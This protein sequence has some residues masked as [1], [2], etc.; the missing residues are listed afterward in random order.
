[1]LGLNHRTPQMRLLFHTFRVNGPRATNLSP[2]NE[3]ELLQ[4]L[5]ARTATITILLADDAAF[6][7]HLLHNILRTIQKFRKLQTVTIQSCT[8][9]DRLQSLTEYL[10]KN[11]SPA[12]VFELIVAEGPQTATSNK[13]RITSLLHILD[14]TRI[15]SLNLEFPCLDD[16]DHTSI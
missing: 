3:L 4:I 10:A 13:T 2:A 1:M 16:A 14:P 5:C 15:R 12:V 7:S 11:T 9:E 6:R 8:S